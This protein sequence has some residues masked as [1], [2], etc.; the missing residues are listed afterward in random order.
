MQ[1]NR[2]TRIFM[3]TVK[4]LVTFL[5]CGLF[6]AVIGGA[7]GGGVGHFVPDYY[8]AVFPQNDKVQY[9]PVSVGIGLGVCQGLPSGV[10]TGLV[11][12]AILTWREIKIRQLPVAP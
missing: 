10:A 3:N 11:L 5:G 9:D 1:E 4:A 8:H 7:I 12:V 2:R 6:G